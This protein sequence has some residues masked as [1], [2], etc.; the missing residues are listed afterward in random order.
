MNALPAQTASNLSLRQAGTST[1]F[2]SMQAV[3]LL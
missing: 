1:R 3:R 2:F